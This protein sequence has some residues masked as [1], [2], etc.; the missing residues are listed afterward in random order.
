M[1]GMPKAAVTQPVARLRELLGKH[2]GRAEIRTYFQRLREAGML[3][4]GKGGR[5][6]A[7]SAQL[8]PLQVALVLL[9]LGSGVG[10]IDAP[11]EAKR[12]GDFRLAGKDEVVQAD[13]EAF[14]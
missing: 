6:G 9:A 10:A 1:G 14:V 5:G 3:P 13:D 2:F 12:I 7:L 11:A 4:E 8:D